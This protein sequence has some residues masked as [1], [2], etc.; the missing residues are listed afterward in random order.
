MEGIVIVSGG[1][2]EAGEEGRKLEE[3]LKSFIKTYSMR[4]LGGPTGGSIIRPSIGLNTSIFDVQPDGGNITFISQST[5]LGRVAA[6]LG[7]AN[8]GVRFSI[9]ISLG[10]MVDIDFG[11]LIDFL[12][13]DTRRGAS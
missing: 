1:F 4:I 11:D 13:E 12:G 3:A 7:A 5:S 2:R 10:S 6:R 9:F 8:R